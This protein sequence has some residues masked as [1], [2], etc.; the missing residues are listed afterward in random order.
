MRVIAYWVLAWVAAAA[1]WL[2]LVDLATAPELIAG[3]IVATLAATG[4]HL[5]RRERLAEQ[6][7]RPGLALRVWRV[8]V[9][10]FPDILRLTRAAFAQLADRRPV[11]GRVI[12]MPFGHVD[13]SAD[14]RTVRA[15]AVGFGSL[16]PNTLVIG[17]DEE[18]GLL[19]VHQLQATGKTSDID[20]MRLR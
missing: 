13:D 17:V 10:V 1:L 4:F 8:A 2:V 5:V 11:R 12:A 9:R 19:L 3:A 20:P 6:A 18:S 15:V 16:A 7:F 14:E